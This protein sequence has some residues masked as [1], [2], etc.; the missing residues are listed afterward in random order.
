MLRQENLMNS[1]EPLDMDTM[2]TWLW[3]LFPMLSSYLQ[4]AYQRTL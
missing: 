4:S 2:N 3:S 1:R